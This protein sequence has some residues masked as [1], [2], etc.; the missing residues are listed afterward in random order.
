MEDKGQMF[1]QHIF[2]WPQEGIVVSVMQDFS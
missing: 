2:I 1:R